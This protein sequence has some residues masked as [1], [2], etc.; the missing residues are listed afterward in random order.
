MAAE[1]VLLASLG[2][3]PDREAA[4]RAGG[5]IAAALAKGPVTICTAGAGPVERIAEMVYALML[6]LYDFNIYR[7]VTRKIFD[8]TPEQLKNIT[9]IVWLYREETK[10]YLHLVQ[11]EG[12]LIL[13]ESS[14]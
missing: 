6:R 7:K 13:Y 10:K 1:K 5:A 2:E 9:A 8:F 14:R 4:R 12:A 3:D 11:E